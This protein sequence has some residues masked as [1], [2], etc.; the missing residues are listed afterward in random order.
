MAADQENG[1]S[2]G[3]QDSTETELT[4]V[5]LEPE[6]VRFLD[7]RVGFANVRWLLIAVL[8]VIALLVIHHEAAVHGWR[9]GPDYSNDE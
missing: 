3:A 8:V 2:R 1:W 9:W 4:P 6:P 7:R 5:E